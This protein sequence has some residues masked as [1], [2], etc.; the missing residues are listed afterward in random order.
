MQ[1]LLVQENGHEKFNV[2][3]VTLQTEIEKVFAG[4]RIS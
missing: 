3:E 1:F 4:G 2:N